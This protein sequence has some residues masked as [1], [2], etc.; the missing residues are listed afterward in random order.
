MD[1]ILDNANSHL[2]S[3]VPG[4]AWGEI[5][6]LAYDWVFRIYVFLLILLPSGGIFG[7]NIK[8]FLFF[9]LTVLTFREILTRDNGILDICFVLAIPLMFSIWILL[10]QLYSVS[11]IDSIAQFKDLAAT[12]G[13]CWF[14]SV[15]VAPGQKKRF[16]FLKLVVYSE[17]FIA[18]AKVGVLVFAFLSHGNVVDTMEA[19]SKLFNVQLMTVDFENSA[20]R[21]QLV[22]DA[23][24][25]LC[26]FTIFCFRRELRIKQSVAVIFSA[27]LLFSIVLTFS[28][29]LWAFG[30]V[31]IILGLLISKKERV[32]LF[33]I[34]LVLS[35]TVYAFQFVSAIFELRFS[36]KTADYSDSPRIVQQA[37]LNDFFYDAPIFGHGFGSHAVNE[38]RDIKLPYSYELQSMALAG[39]LGIVG[40]ALLIAVL[41]YYFR[42]SFSFNRGNRLYQTSVLML[43]VFWLTA[44]FFNP[45]LI[46]S[47]AA[48]SYG[49]L[50][51]L[52]RSKLG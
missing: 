39:Q 17:C 22:S 8:M 43:V 18:L 26:A 14:A 20:G 19:I 24:A 4:I 46:S 25:P 13:G 33:F 7:I 2:G 3:D 23:L 47:T 27:L 44:G 37:A 41:C 35:L 9:V 28:R 42:G 49:T 12:L 32:H 38:I 34:A 51:A 40:L 21:I 6:N 31:A 36:E 5:A 50:L 52:A 1:E 11:I 15:F 30:V 48:L 29:Y 16:Q 10:S 45:Y